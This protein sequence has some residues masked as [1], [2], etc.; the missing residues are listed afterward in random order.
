MVVGAV[1]AAG[2]TASASSPLDALYQKLD[3]LA[4]VFG[5]IENHYVDS[6][7]ATD[8]VYGAARGALGVLDPHSTFFSPDEY[9][10]LLDATE[11]EYAGIGIEMEMRQALPDV[12]AVFEESPAAR[13]GLLRGDQIVTARVMTPTDLSGEQRELL[14]RLGHS[15]KSPDIHETAHRGFF[16]K[17]K[18]AFG[19]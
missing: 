6:I 5:Q 12:M 13:A 18:D 4:E 16:D 2:A 10:S 14:E 3:I 1:V 15:L 9:K 19:V 11:G 7:V 8:L 17:I